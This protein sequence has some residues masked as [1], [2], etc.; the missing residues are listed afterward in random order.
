MTNNIKKY[1]NG[2]IYKLKCINPN[3]SKE[4]YVGH[5][6]QRYL[7]TRLIQHRSSANKNDSKVY[8][9]MKGTGIHNWQIYLLENYPCNSANEIRAREQYW[10]NL[11][12]PSLNTIDVILNKKKSIEK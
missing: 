9:V 12:Q 7:N 3:I 2:K 4:E 8:T 10:I 6:T 11:L 5:T 1:Q